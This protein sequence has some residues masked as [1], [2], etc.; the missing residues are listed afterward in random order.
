[1][2]HL[3][4]A[5]LALGQPHMGAT[6]LDQGVGIG[7]PEGIHHRRIC[8][9]NGVVLSLW[10]VSPAI[11]DCQYHWSHWGQTALHKG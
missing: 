7:M 11:E 3:G 1:M 10:L 5:H 6:G 2:P 8:G 9:A 4:I